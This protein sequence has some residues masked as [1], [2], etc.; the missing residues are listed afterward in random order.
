MNSNDLF[1]EEHFD[2]LE[3][4]FTNIEYDT[5]P[6]YDTETEEEFDY[7]LI[8]YLEEEEIITGFKTEETNKTLEQIINRKFTE[9]NIQEEVDDMIIE[10]ITELGMTYKD[11]YNKL[12]EYY[13]LPL[14]ENIL[15][16]KTMLSDFYKQEQSFMDDNLCDKYVRKPQTRKCKC[17]ICKDDNSENE[18]IYSIY[19]NRED[20]K[21]LTKITYTYVNTEQKECK[22]NWINRRGNNYIKCY[23][24]GY[25]PSIDKRS[26]CDI[27]FKEIC[28]L[29][30]KKLFNLEMNI[31]KEIKKT[32]DTEKIE[33][34]EIIAE[35]HKLK[36]NNL[37]EKIKY[38]ENIIDKK[39]QKQDEFETTQMIEEYTY[40]HT[41]GFSNMI[42][43]QCRLWL[44]NNTFLDLIALLD[45]GA[46]KSV[47]SYSLIP[48][49]YHRKLHYKLVTRTVEDRLISIT[50]YIEPIGI[51]FLDFAGNYSIK[52]EIP[53]VNINPEYI[54]STNFVLGLN[55]ILGLNGAITITKN[56]T[57]LSKHISSLP[58]SRST[59]T[60]EFARKRGGQDNL[61][62]FS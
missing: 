37:E 10:C 7:S 48:K 21:S 41:K 12:Q 11:S 61:E 9:L 49:Q 38:I 58:T 45:T 56:F 43:L 19:S 16:G 47:V 20:D 5:E 8:D 34:L 22:H 57:T 17:F 3:Y 53:Q 6:I 51:Q 55:F 52:Y 36:I 15:Q 4:N 35:L 2:F 14:V 59:N 40:I 33:R 44:T 26:Q 28:Y 42:N 50:H 62:F 18:S 23:N 60:S 31:Q 39:K 25:Y 30:L 24:C 13:N 27:C 46:T 32:I 54:K 29:C 1:V